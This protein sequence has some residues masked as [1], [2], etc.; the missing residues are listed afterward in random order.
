[1]MR[2][3]VTFVVLCVAACSAGT[4]DPSDTTADAATTTSTASTTT[5]SVPAG[6]TVTTAPTTTTTA[7]VLDPHAAPSWLGTRALPLRP[8]GYGEVQPTPPELIDR[9]ISTV[10]LLGPP[11]GTAFESTISPIPPDVLDRST[12]S[13]GCPVT[14]DQLAY[15]TVAHWG[16]DGD[17]HTGELIVHAD[18]AA[19]IVEVFARLH[20]ARFPIEQMRVIRSD[21]LDLAPTG[22]GNITTAFVCRP[23][24]GSASWSMH[25]SGL[26]IDINPF[27]NPYVKGDLVLPE[28]ASAYADRADSRDGMIVEG[29]AV[30]EAFAAIGW[31]WGGRWTSLTD[32]MHFSV[33]NR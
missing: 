28:L 29:G 26:A 20:D 7:T 23:A 31:H 11:D 5:T 17:V 2:L 10:D 16:F 25:A 12:W 3:T 6:T 27:H 18:H 30:T 21:E 15:V 4:V 22:D 1:E 32:P 8:D 33:N 13:K 9:S 19:G 14:P 24:V